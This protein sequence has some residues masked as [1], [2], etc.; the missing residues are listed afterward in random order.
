MEL[1]LPAPIGTISVEVFFE[2]RKRITLRI[3]PD[4]RVQVSAPLSAEPDLVEQ[5]ILKKRPWI[6]RH[7]ERLA[8]APPPAP[9]SYRHGT[10]HYFLGSPFTL[11]PLRAGRSGVMIEDGRLLVSSRDPEDERTVEAALRRWYRKQAESIVHE[12]IRIRSPRFQFLP[13]H[14]IGFRWMRSRWGSCARS[15]LI[16]FNTQLVKTPMACVDFVVAHELCHL[17]HH[18]HG[19][20]FRSLLEEVMPGW[21]AAR[22]LLKELPLML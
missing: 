16:V 22:R 7:L 2:P 18:N 5:V 17:I 4:G 13:G 12:R 14:E 11:V 6:A 20:G 3:R 9:T 1:D 10:V 21:R 8:G 15:G 19:A